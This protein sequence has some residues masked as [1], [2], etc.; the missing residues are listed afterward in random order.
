MKVALGN[1]LGMFSPALAGREKSPGEA[2]Q[3]WASWI[4]GATGLLMGIKWTPTEI[5]A[6]AKVLAKVIA[7]HKKFLI[8]Q[9][10]LVK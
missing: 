4:V 6:L 8:D 3:K 9:R 7:N 5:D 2:A 10:K 1:L